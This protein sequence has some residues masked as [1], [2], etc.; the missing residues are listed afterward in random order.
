[1]TKPARKHWPLAEAK[2]HLSEVVERAE[3]EGP[4]RLTRHGKDA[5]FVV[6]VAQW[7]R[8]TAR[9][10]PLVQLL[11][12]SGLGELDLRRDPDPGRDVDL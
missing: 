3:R 10:K 6:S 12:E 5:A 7:K 9:R 2:S 1:M 4:Q 11:Q 8:L